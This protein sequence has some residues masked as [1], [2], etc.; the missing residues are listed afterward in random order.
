MPGS[1]GP[2]TPTQQDDSLVFINEKVNVSHN[3]AATSPLFDKAS[4]AL[5]QSSDMI[6]NSKESAETQQ[7]DSG[8]EVTLKRHSQ[9]DDTQVINSHTQ[10]LSVRDSTQVME[11]THKVSQNHTQNEAG[12]ADTQVI[13]LLSQKIGSRH[14]RSQVESPETYQGPKSETLDADPET[15]HLNFKQDHSPNKTTEDTC[16]DV[17]NEKGLWRA[18]QPFTQIISPLHS[19]PNGRENPSSP[20]EST[21]Q[22]LN[23]QEDVLVDIGPTDLGCRSVY[24]S[25][26]N[27]DY[28]EVVSNDEYDV[29]TTVDDAPSKVEAID[30]ESTLIDEPHD[31]NE[32]IKADIS[33]GLGAGFPRDEL[34][35]RGHEHSQDAPSTL[36]G[37]E[38][39]MPRKRRRFDN[40]ILRVE[41]SLQLELNTVRNYLAVWAFAQFKY[42]PAKVIDAVDDVSS[43]VEYSDGIQKHVKN[44]DLRLLDIRVGDEISLMDQTKGEFLVC[45]LAHDEDSRYSCCRGFSSVYVMKKEKKGKGIEFQ[46]PLAI[47]VIDMAQMALHQQRFLLFVDSLDLVQENYTTIKAITEGHTVS[48]GTTPRKL[49]KSSTT[50]SDTFHGMLFF[51]TSVDD[52]RKDDLEKQVTVNGGILIDDEIQHYVECVE[53]DGHLSLTLNEF[54]GYKFGALLLTGHSRSAKY[55]QALSLGWPVLKDTFVDEAIKDPSIIESW[56][57]FLLPAGNLLL[58]N[59][60]HSVDVFGFRTK[61]LKNIE[62]VDQL[63]NNSELLRAYDIIIFNNRQDAFVLQMCIFIFHAFGALLVRVL[64]KVANVDEAVLQGANM[65]YDNNLGEYRRAKKAATR[66][67]SKVAVVDWEWLVQC[68]ISS[69]IWPPLRIQV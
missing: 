53:T 33:E 29:D 1:D 7:R 50:V 20:N 61:W 15:S 55:L 63:N 28:K 14:T 41:P 21:A 37:D 4:F 6:F 32:P 64:A 9:F 57:A 60:L 22:V 25:S 2:I 46:V 65:V 18:T 30:A 59:S 26:Q 44:L 48:V 13:P 43:L 10:R 31:V 49:A 19:S 5:E 34:R 62:L 45:G 23:T 56:Q 38:V 42:F 54:D 69:H 3:D 11:K 68:V 36:S 8:H 35:G 17:E 24:S 51:V 67:Q 52:K 16:T 39:Q 66:L 40:G 27:K 12:L 58:T 47:C